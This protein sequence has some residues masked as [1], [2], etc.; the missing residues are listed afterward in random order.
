MPPVSGLRLRLERP[1]PAAIA[2][3]GG[4]HVTLVGWCYHPAGQIVDLRITLDGRPV[5]VP[6]FRRVRPDI[7]LTEHPTNDPAG[8]SMDGGFAATIELPAVCRETP[9]A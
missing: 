3:G 8:Y 4:N 5:D 7:H 1:L 6:V 9:T 2:V